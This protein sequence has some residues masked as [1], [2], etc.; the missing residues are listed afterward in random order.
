MRFYPRHSKVTQLQALR[1]ITSLPLSLVGYMLM[2]VKF[3]PRKISRSSR[4]QTPYDI[5]TYK[6]VVFEEVRQQTRWERF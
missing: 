1:E 4:L 6:F 3:Y 2:Y 5:Q